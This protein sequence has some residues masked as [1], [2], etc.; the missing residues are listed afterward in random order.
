[1]NEEVMKILKMVESKVITAE[2]GQK[3]MATIESANKQIDI[4]RGNDLGRFLHIDVDANEEGDETTVE[5]NIPLK[6]AKA[7]LKMGFVQDQINKNSL[8]DIHIDTEEIIRLIDLD[9]TGDLL[10][11]DSKDAKVRIWID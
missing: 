3:L 2:E 1:M 9:Y 7:F 8:E 10:S 5:V 11:V 4:A 6:A